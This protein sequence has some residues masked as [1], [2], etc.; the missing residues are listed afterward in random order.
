MLPD[1]SA[2]PVHDHAGCMEML[3]GDQ[4]LFDELM[5]LYSEN[6]GQTVQRLEEALAS[7]DSQEIARCAHSIKGSSA[8]LCVER[9][10]ALASDLERLAGSEDSVE[11]SPFVAAIKVEFDAFLQDIVP[12]H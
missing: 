3:D 9:V 11:L 12:S 8:N 2:V 5:E 4:E 7:G 10:R 6:T 1:L